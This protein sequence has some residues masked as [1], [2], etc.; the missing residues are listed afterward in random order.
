MNPLFLWYQSNSGTHLPSNIITEFDISTPSFITSFVFYSHFPMNSNNWQ[1][2]YLA[3]SSDID[4][5]DTVW[6]SNFDS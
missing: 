1:V 5:N 2:F 6:Q 3:Y 4:F